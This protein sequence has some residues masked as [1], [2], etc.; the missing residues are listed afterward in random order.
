MTSHFCCCAKGQV[1]LK[2]R[3]VAQRSPQLPLASDAPRCAGPTLT[4]PGLDAGADLPVSWGPAPG[5]DCE[6]DDRHKTA[7]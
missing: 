2:T 6:Q 7:T 5:G 4:A 1:F 3:K